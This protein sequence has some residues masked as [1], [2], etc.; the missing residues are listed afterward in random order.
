[1]RVV[2]LKENVEQITD[3]ARSVAHSA[4]AERSAW[5]ARSFS[6]AAVHRALQTEWLTSQRPDMHCWAGAAGVRRVS[7]ARA[8]CRERHTQALDVGRALHPFRGHGE[9]SPGT[10]SHLG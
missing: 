10:G 5:P 3:L 2:G 6:E 1:M 8:E 7:T 9:L 4:A